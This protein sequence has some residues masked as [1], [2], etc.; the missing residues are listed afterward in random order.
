VSR[1][2]AAADSAAEVRS[3]C[4]RRAIHRTKGQCW[5]HI[6]PGPAGGSLSRQPQPGC[7]PIREPSRNP[8]EA[9]STPSPATRWRIVTDHPSLH[10]SLRSAG[11]ISLPPHTPCRLGAADRW[12]DRAGGRVQIAQL[13]PC[14]LPPGI[15]ARRQQPERGYEPAHGSQTPITIAA[16]PDPQGWWE[17]ERSG[18]E[19][20]SAGD[21]GEGRLRRVPPAWLRLA[22]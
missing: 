14:W 6:N 17:G 3:P 18:G 8:S 15:A 10:H 21:P 9:D 13:W 19:R 16:S 1:D 7:Q 2:G 20:A 22:G 12:G 11:P 5:R 4:Y